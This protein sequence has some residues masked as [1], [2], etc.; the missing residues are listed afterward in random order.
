M[1]SGK[2]TVGALLFGVDMECSKMSWMCVFGTVLVVS[3]NDRI[4]D[5]VVVRI[6]DPVT[7]FSLCSDVNEYIYRY[8]LALMGWHKVRY[9]QFH[10]HPPIYNNKN[11]RYFWV[12]PK[13]FPWFQGSMIEDYLFK[14][15]YLCPNIRWISREF[16]CI[17]KY[18]T[19]YIFTIHPMPCI[20][21]V[22]TEDW[23]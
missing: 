6:L 16:K 17:L 11:V 23:Q 2:C 8:I 9:I 22:H 4:R 18:K 20:Y 10:T 15:F 5:S 19:S 3:M 7:R 13:W 21:I 12:K 14:C 1:L